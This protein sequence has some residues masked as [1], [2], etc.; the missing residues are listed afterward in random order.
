VNRGERLSKHRDSLFSTK[1]VE[2]VPVSL[3]KKV[4]LCTSEGMSKCT[5]QVQTVNRLVRKGSGVQRQ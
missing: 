4:K 2:A 3:Y 1:A 5:D